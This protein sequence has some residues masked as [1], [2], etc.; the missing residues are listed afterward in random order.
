MQQP[1]HQQQQQQQQPEGRAVQGQDSFLA[2]SN[3][4]ITPQTASVDVSPYSTPSEQLGWLTQEQELPL[5]QQPKPDLARTVQPG[6]NIVSVAHTPWSGQQPGLLLH[7]QGTSP[8]WE[9]HGQGTSPAW[10][11]RGISPNLPPVPVSGKD[12]SPAW[13]QEQLQGQFHAP[14]PASS[15]GQVLQ[16]PCNGSGPKQGPR[17]VQSS[18]PCLHN[19]AWTHRQDSDSLLPANV[20]LAGPTQWP[21]HSSHQGPPSRQAPSP[22]FATYS[23]SHVSHPLYPH[24]DLSRPLCLQQP[25]AFAQ[26]AVSSSGLMLYSGS[27]S[28]AGL[29]A[30]QN[31]QGCA[32]S[33]CPAGP[34]DGPYLPHPGSARLSGAFQQQ[35]A[36]FPVEQASNWPYQSANPAHQGAHQVQQASHQPTEASF[37]PNEPAHQVQQAP[38]Q[39]HQVTQQQ[40]QQQQHASSWSD[41]PAYQRQ[42]FSN[43]QQP[44]GHLHQ[45]L[46]AS[47]PHRWL[48][49]E[50]DSAAR[51]SHQAEQPMHQGA[52]QTTTETWLQA[53]RF[54]PQIVPQE[55]S[56]LQ[57]QQGI[58]Q[59]GVLQH[60]EAVMQQHIYHQQQPQQQALLTGAAT[61]SLGAKPS[62]ACLAPGHPPYTAAV[63]VATAADQD[64]PQHDVHTQPRFTVVQTPAAWAQTSRHD[65]Q[66]HP[67]QQHKQNGCFGVP[68]QLH[69]QL[70]Q[71][72]V[73]D[74]HR[75]LPQQLQHT[76]AATRLHEQVH[77]GNAESSQ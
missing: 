9:P 11:P 39:P 18:A 5:L 34:P 41:Q 70:Q 40:Q 1:P 33:S 75:Q 68:Q 30:G 73:C 47:P 22:A 77:A 3:W 24:L 76:P 74:S 8:A 67:H 48:R 69:R 38:Y 45:A 23:P 61:S 42:V 64:Q 26:S 63:A 59:Q 35:E 55:R 52:V 27:P 17:G 71:Q 14:S 12:N 65:F 54:S 36:A 2:C 56:S 43:L 15:L 66:L 25:S 4:S 62:L 28:L 46:P 60:Q 58:G 13:L 31:Q 72:R 53:G 6:R 7:G 10:E 32:A 44:S 37:W 16:Q 29:R 57:Q 21:M 51:L 50:L 20:G 49:A 19:P